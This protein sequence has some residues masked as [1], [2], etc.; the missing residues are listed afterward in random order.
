MSVFTFYGQLGWK[1]KSVDHGDGQVDGGVDQQL[2][3]DQLPQGASPSA[4]VH[5][6]QFIIFP[7]K[8]NLRRILLC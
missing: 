7:S 1:C 3:P 5:F 6:Y 4:I 2:Q 8:A